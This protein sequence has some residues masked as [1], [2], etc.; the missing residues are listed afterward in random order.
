MCFE[1][2]MYRNIAMPNMNTIVNSERI[3][4]QLLNSSSTTLSTSHPL[5]AGRR[6]PAPR[7]RYFSCLCRP[8]DTLVRYFA[9]FDRL[10]M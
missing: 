1:K 8:D 5:G 9:G 2:K 3:P 4:I 10:Q 6:L 7:A